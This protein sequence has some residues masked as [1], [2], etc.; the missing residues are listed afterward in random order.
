V[1]I[2]APCSG[3]GTWRRNPESR[4]RLTPAELGRLADL[5][6][7]LLS[8]AA[9]L[10]KPGGRITYI[11]CSLLDEEGKDQ[12]ERFLAVRPQFTA[13]ALDLPLGRPHGPGVR[14]TPHHDGTDGFFIASLSAA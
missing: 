1:L 7:R 6:Q 11:T 14:L 13:Q 2:D 12:I 10:V 9:D 4:W 8:V 3:T 5:Q